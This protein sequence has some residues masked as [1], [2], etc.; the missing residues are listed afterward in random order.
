MKWFILNHKIIKRIIMIGSVDILNPTNYSQSFI[1]L[2]RNIDKQK[3]NSFIYNKQRIE[4]DFYS[5]ISKEWKILN[6]NDKKD[7]IDRNKHFYDLYQSSIDNCSFIFNIKNINHLMNLTS[8]ILYNNPIRECKL[9]FNCLYLGNNN[10]KKY[11][12]NNN[13]DNRDDNN[14]NTLY[15]YLNN[16]LSIKFK[17]NHH[18]AIQSTDINYLY[19]YDIISNILNHSSCYFIISHKTLLNIKKNLLNILFSTLNHLIIINQ[20]EEEEINEEKREENLTKNN[21]KY[22]GDITKFID[23]IY[24]SDKRF[25]VRNTLNSL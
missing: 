14:N 20:E 7:E 19:Q 9:I 1:D 17:N 18:L 16:Q 3:I 21:I 23:D 11:I 12:K 15:S 25:N 22:N 10:Q 8:S 6:Y 13:N 24:N 4:N 2:L 5:L